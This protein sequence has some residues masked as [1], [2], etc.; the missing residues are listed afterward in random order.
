MKKYIKLLFIL[1]GAVWLG[2]LFADV[3]A[4]EE[5]LVR[6]HVVA[7]SDSQTDQAVKL[8]VRDAVLE[9]LKM[10][11]VRDIG[12]AKAYIEARIPE[13][14]A[15]A[16]AVLADAGSPDRAVVTLTREEFPVREYN[17]FRLPSGVYQSLRVTIGP[18]EGKNWWCV[19]YPELCVPATSQGFAEAAAM[20][21]MDETL[22]GALTGDYEIRFW[23]LD[24]IGELRNFLHRD[25]E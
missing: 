8:R 25:S 18:G 22:T 16:N 12:Q 2:G 5:D 7:A 13:L 6:L 15:A 24:K 10:E 9:A 1:A 4:L 20:D 17:T 3:R 11:N 19:V 14:E 23:L 21:G